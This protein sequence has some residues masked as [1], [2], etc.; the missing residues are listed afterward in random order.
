M[1]RFLLV[2]VLQWNKMIAEKSVDRVGG[3]FV[4]SK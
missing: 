3:V 2:Q 1:T 4:G